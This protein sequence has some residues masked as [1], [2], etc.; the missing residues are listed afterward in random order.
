MACTLSWRNQI[1]L[2]EELFRAVQLRGEANFITL[3]S[4]ALSNHNQ[5]CTVEIR[6]QKDRPIGSNQ[7]IAAEAQPLAD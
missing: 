1:V 6:M 5:R 7:N 3:H 2:S 4:R